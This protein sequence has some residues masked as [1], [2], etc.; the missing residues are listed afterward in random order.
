VTL[1]G[2]PYPPSARNVGLQALQDARDEAA[3]E[4]ADAIQRVIPKGFRGRITATVDN[5]VVRAHDV[6]IEMR[7]SQPRNP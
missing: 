4:I 5:G 6:A 7:P 2:Y 3:R 1:T